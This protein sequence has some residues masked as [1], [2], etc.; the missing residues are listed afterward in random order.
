MDARAAAAGWSASRVSL[1]GVVEQRPGV[2][3]DAVQLWGLPRL[4]V[5]LIP[6]FGLE[7]GSLG[8]EVK[9]SLL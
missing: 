1:E 4:H 6:Q 9:G 5:G 8:S 2:G 3:R 7:P